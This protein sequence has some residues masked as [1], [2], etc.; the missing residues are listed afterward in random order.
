VIASL[1]SMLLLWWL[2][3]KRSSQSLRSGGMHKVPLSS[4]DFAKANGN[5][6]NN[7]ALPTE[8]SKLLLGMDQDG[9]PV[10]NSYERAAATE[11][12]DQGFLIN[13]PP[14]CGIK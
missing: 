6:T 12:D 4:R 9:R 2:R 1:L 10:M 13:V 8:T 7:G 3:C 5:G 11:A 14:N